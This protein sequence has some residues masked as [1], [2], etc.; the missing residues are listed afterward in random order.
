[1]ITLL[2][3]D[4]EPALLEIGRLF[5]QRDTDII[6]DTAESADAALESMKTKSYDAIVSDYQ[7][8]GMN[9]IEFL[10]AIR[11]AGDPIPFIIF[12][13]KGREEVVI[14]ALNDGADFYL[15]K[16]GDPRSQFAELS[17]KIRQAVR[18]RRD[19]IA[20]ATSEERFRAIVQNA[21]DMIRIL[22]PDGRIIFETGAAERILGY[23]PGETLGRSPLEYIH[24]DDLSCVTEEL[25]TVFQRTNNGVPTEFRIRKADG[26]YIW[27]ESIAV[28]LIGVPGVNGIITTTR[29]ID[30]RKRSEESIRDYQRREADIINFLP[31]ATFAI[32][33]EG[34]VITW[35]R[36]IE[37]MTGVLSGDILGKGN[38][39]YAIPFY[40]ERRPLLIDLVLSYDPV[41]AEKYPFI[42]RS[43]DTLFSEISIPHLRKG[44]GATLW[45]TATP[46]YNR[47]GEVIG[48]IE[49]IRDITDWKK[50]EQEVHQKLDELSAA[51]EQIAA[52]E[53]ELRHQMEALTETEQEL[54]ESNEFLEGLFNHANGPIIVWNRFGEI[55]RFND[56][57]QLLTG[58]P[59]DEAIGKS[60]R[61]LF[62]GDSE[63]TSMDLIH[64]AISGEVWDAVEIPILSRDG[65]IRTVLWNSANIRIGDEERDTATI[66][67]GQDIT[68]R[69]RMEKTLL[70]SESR[71]RELTELL[72]QAVY[73]TDLEGR[74]TY[75][76]R[77]AFELFGYTREDFDAGLNA[78]SMIHP[79]DLLR[80]VEN[81]QEGTTGKRTGISTHEYRAVSRNGSIFPIVVYSSP[82]HRE[83]G[84][85]G[86]RGIVIDITEQ[87]QSEN[88][89]RREQEFTQLL[90]DT[91]PVF[92]VAI[93]EDGK[94]LKMNSALL[95][96]LEYEERVLIGEDYVSTVVPVEEQTDLEEILG[97]L[98]KTGEM[99][100]N[101]NHIIS[102]SG[103]QIPVEW[104][105]RR[106]PNDDGSSGF[107]VGVGIDISERMLAEEALL[108]ANRQLNLLSSITRH[109]ILN[110]ITTLLGYLTLSLDLVEDQQ[111]KKYLHEVELAAETIRHHIDFTRVYQDLGTVEPKW[112]VLEDMVPRKAI[113]ANITLKTDLS[114]ISIYAD[115]ML[116]KVF[117]NLLDN[118]VK[119]GERVTTIS[120]YTEI[121][122]GE[123]YIIWEDDGIGIAQKEK[124][125]IFERGVGKNTGLGLF[126]VREVLAITKISIQEKGEEGTGARFEMRV[127]DGGYRIEER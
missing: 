79:D 18:L 24:P 70:E 122:E 40:H 12:T 33:P 103:R 56:A 68:E 124:E 82:I 16:G 29:F 118:S 37:E 15:Q 59:E 119:H 111:L 19:D 114:Q 100:L 28:N 107:I 49:A 87:K 127:P 117:L 36:A 30:E 75:A 31:D 93:G 67:L 58:I 46:L 102:R 39:E 35:N 5:L 125:R 120:V 126:L 22:D 4:D 54:R 95:E 51:F 71:F 8:P 77:M 73:E 26:S 65:T 25:M 113:P 91:L 74:L 13:G 45:F 89:L 85:A 66:A 115:P 94:I 78:L 23:Q 92:F 14:E 110:K 34:R 20:L 57:F 76:N 106:V 38:Y 43:N 72:P 104:H 27:A 121:R 1:M 61:M 62:P 6:V 81:F 52:T 9:G 69:K 17:H 42:T 44:A 41:L 90:L 83:G 105:G 55:T 98:L 11:S 80:A 7:M 10:K 53:E 88:A 97:G 50:A 3:V 123:L 86:L 96:A 116:E 99:T 21:S 2:Y 60:P 63:E 48:A 84:I 112:Q 64:Q 108:Q 101:Q 109:D 32:D 47:N